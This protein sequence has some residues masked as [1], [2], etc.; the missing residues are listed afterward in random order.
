[1]PYYSGSNVIFEKMLYSYK[2]LMLC[3][4]KIDQ[5]KNRIDDWVAIDCLILGLSKILDK[6]V[7]IYKV[8]KFLMDNNV[9]INPTFD[10]MKYG[11]LAFE[12]YDKFYRGYLTNSDDN[13]RIFG[14]IFYLRLKSCFKFDM[15]IPSW[16]NP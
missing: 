7:S 13:T 10:A 1:M 2:Y 6:Y 9:E 11:L 12:N 15:E 3:A 5:E 4:D 16:F 8:N 14:K